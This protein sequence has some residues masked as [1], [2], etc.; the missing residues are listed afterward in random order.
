MSHSTREEQQTRLSSLPARLR[1]NSDADYEDNSNWSTSTYND[2]RSFGHI[3]GSSAQQ[4]QLLY[5]SIKMYNVCKEV[6]I[7]MLVVVTYAALTNEYVFCFCINIRCLNFGSLYQEVLISTY[8]VYCIQNAAVDVFS[9]F[10]F[11]A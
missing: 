11:A 10:I 9:I 8:M 2:Q 4:S 1:T 5:Y 3:N 6:A 7:M